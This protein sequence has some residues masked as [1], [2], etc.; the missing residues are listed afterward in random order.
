MTKKHDIIWIETVDST[1]SEAVRQISAL[2]NLSV[3][4]AISQSEGRG[5]RGNVWL[6]SPGK[7]LTFSIVLK[8][9]NYPLPKFRAA[10]QATI[11]AITSISV[12]ELLSNYGIK[13]KIKLPNDIYINDKKICG[14]L[15]EHAV[16][17]EYLEHSIVGIGLNVNQCNFDVSLSNPTSIALCLNTQTQIS[18]KDCLEHFMDIYKRNLHHLKEGRD[19]TELFKT[20]LA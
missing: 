2:D 16:K 9:E 10:D 3:L 5:Q 8:Y 15:I 19:F 1:N 20:M 4:S 6:S 13:A 18:T 11:S 7:N 14:I 17:G 12:V